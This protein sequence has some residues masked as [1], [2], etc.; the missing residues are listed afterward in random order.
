MQTY[1]KQANAMAV[2][3]YDDKGYSGCAD[4]SLELWK[5][6]EEDNGLKIIEEKKVEL[7]VGISVIK[8]REDGRLVAVGDFD[9]RVH[10]FGSKKLKYL[11][12]I[13][14]HNDS[15]YDIIFLPFNNH[16]CISS[17]S[18]VLSFWDL[19]S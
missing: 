7:G 5:I 1:K 16:L 3:V 2:D 18:P 14:Y 8:V 6:E 19:Y 17:Q 4:G 12:C 13:S 15:L 11:V 9:G 10:M